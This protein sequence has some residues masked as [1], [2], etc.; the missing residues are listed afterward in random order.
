MEYLERMDISR[1]NEKIYTALKISR[2][3][4]FIPDL[5]LNIYRTIRNSFRLQI[6]PVTSKIFAH[7]YQNMIIARY[8]KF[9]EEKIKNKVLDIGAYR[10][11]FTKA[12]LNLGYQV[13][14][15]EPHPLMFEYL[16]KYF[17]NNEDVIIINKA[18]T[19]TESRE[20]LYLNS[21]YH[22]DPV[23]M[24]IGA[25]LVQH[26][27]GVNTGPYFSVETMK[28]SKLF[29]NGEIYSLVKIDIEGA[30]MNLV[31]DLIYFSDRIERLLVETHYRFMDNSSDRQYYK[32]QMDELNTFIAVNELSN[33]RTD[34]I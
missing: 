19:N 15:V 14:S 12:C 13:I 6:S 30:E 23:A 25:S 33:W 21:M 22:Y 34:W 11:N 7:K 26:K 24:S 28:L 9:K 18:I 20:N 32:K 16:S 29:D 3:R 5:L 31:D 27:Y 17:Y 2:I 4:E 10:G 8:P 1:L